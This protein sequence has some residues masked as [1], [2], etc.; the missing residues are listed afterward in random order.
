MIAYEPQPETCIA[1]VRVRAQN[2]RPFAPER[3]RAV[4]E[5]RAA[6]KDASVVVGL[7][8]RRL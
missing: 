3:L 6:E 5:L 8:Y 1:D 7:K 4:P 2:R